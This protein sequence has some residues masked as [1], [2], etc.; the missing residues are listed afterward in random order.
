MGCEE[1]VLHGNEPPR[2]KETTPPRNAIET[3]I[4]AFCG[5]MPA[6]SRP[7]DGANI[8]TVG[9]HVRHTPY[10]RT[11]AMHMHD[12]KKIVAVPIPLD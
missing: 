2:L 10:T 9:A 12:A 11:Y 7:E 3:T 1:H 4:L 6:V 5:R 8:L